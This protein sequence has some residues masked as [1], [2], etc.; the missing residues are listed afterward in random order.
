MKFKE[1]KFKCKRDMFLMVLGI[2]E[3]FE[4]ADYESRGKRG[5][6]IDS[7][8]GCIINLLLIYF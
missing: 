3:T 1:I 7:H 6:D 4:F 8:F 5:S 2:R